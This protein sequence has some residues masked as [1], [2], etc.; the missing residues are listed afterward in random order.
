MKN[1]SRLSKMRNLIEIIGESKDLKA[2]CLIMMMKVMASPNVSRK[3]KSG[4]VK[5]KKNVPF[6][7][8]SVW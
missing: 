2:P 7:I 8:R 6:I 5:K 4:R 1:P 3:T